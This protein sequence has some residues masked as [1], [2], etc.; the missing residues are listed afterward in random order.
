MGIWCSLESLHQNQLPFSLMY[1]YNSNRF[2]DRMSDVQNTPQGKLCLACSATIKVPTQNW[3][4]HRFS[5]IHIGFSDSSRTWNINT[6]WLTKMKGVTMIFIAMLGTAAFFMTANGLFQPDNDA[7][8][9]EQ[10]T[11]TL[12]LP[13]FRGSTIK[14]PSYYTLNSLIRGSYTSM[15]QVHLYIYRSNMTLYTQCLFLVGYNINI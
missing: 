14:L 5:D 13:P 11:C 2:C 15:Q 8:E 6:D 4:F 12:Q 3:K 10:F 7:S 1:V 9:F